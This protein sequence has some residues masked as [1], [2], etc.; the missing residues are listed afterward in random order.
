M[1]HLRTL[2]IVAGCKLDEVHPA[3]TNP[4]TVVLHEDVVVL[5]NAVKIHQVKRQTGHDR[6]VFQHRLHIILAVQNDVEWP[7]TPHL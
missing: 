7:K 1:L 4:G 5:L 3:V 6:N 2:D